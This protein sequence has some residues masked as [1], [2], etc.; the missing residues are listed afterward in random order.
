MSGIICPE[1]ES[2]LKFG[3]HPHRG[4]R[5]H[6]ARC[7]AS[8]VVVGV[9]PPE[10]EVVTPANQA[11]KSKKQAGMVETTCPQCDYMLKLSNRLR[12]G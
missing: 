2:P 1:C 5:V 12:Q 8:L 10:L 11:P 4:Q 6:C 3:G 7:K 9:K